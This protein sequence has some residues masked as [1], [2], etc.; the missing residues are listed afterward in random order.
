MSLADSLNATKS[1]NITAANCT[2]S[3]PEAFVGAT[4][5]VAI[6]SAMVVAAIK[7]HQM[8]QADD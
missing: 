3:S 6:G 8:G 2:Y 1:V 5:G 4:P 7:G